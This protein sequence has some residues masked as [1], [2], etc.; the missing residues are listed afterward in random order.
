MKVL[1]TGGAGFI[2][3]HIVERLVREG[4]QVVAYDNLASGKRENLAHVGEIK[5]AGEL[6]LVVADVRDAPQLDY[7]ASGCDVIFHEAAVVSVPYSV[8]HPQETHDVNIQGTLNVLH[9]AKR[10]SVKRVV[11]ACS[12]AVYGEDPEMPKRETMRAAPMSPYGIE[13]ITGEYYMSVWTQ[14]YGV[15]TVSLRY[16]NVFGERQ[17]PASPYSGVISIFVDRVLKGSGVTIF[18]DGLQYRDF[19]YVGNVVDANIR[20]ATTPGIG[21]RAYNVGCGQKTT[22]LDLLSTIE[23]IA[24]SKVERTMAPPRAGDIRESI[25]DIGRISDE[26]G[27]RPTVG[28]EEGLRRLIEY[29]KGSR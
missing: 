16:F 22:L 23:R 26:L 9:S 3:S 8:E 2:G 25:A 17:D 28:V 12:A 27:Y 15:E 7:Y 6:E 11:F 1:V 14:L 10:R 20:A 29:V 18:G 24:G 5:G 13:K 21:G 4:H 19:V